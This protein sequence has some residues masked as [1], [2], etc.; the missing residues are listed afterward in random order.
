MQICLG[1]HHAT[2]AA[3]EILENSFFDIIVC[4][5]GEQTIVELVESLKKN[6]ELE[7]VDGIFFK[8]NNTH[9]IAGWKKAQ[10]SNDTFCNL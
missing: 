10:P 1:G 7:K 2:F 5:E 6:T 3:E 8:R 9:K 4:G